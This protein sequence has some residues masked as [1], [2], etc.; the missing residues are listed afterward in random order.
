MYAGAR[1]EGWPLGIKMR[2][3]H[4]AKSVVGKEDPANLE[5]MRTRQFEHVNR[6]RFVHTTEIIDMDSKVSALK[7]QS[8]REILMAFKASN[9]KAPLVLNVGPGDKGVGFNI[10]VLPQYKTE[11]QTMLNSLYPYLKH[12]VGAERVGRLKKV[13]SDA[14]VRRC[15]DMIWDEATGSVRSAISIALAALVNNEDD[16]VYFEG[17]DVVQEHEQQQQHQQQQVAQY[18]TNGRRRIDRFRGYSYG[19][20]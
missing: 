13:F 16:A 18:R 3:V 10:Y 8:I 1:K 7:K 6:V 12:Q 11:A 5:T 9:P 4:D 20:P 19:S 17:M 14:V 15:Q 2:F